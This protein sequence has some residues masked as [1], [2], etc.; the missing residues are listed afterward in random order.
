M[1]GGQQGIRPTSTTIERTNL[2]HIAIHLALTS[3]AHDTIK[4]LCANSHTNATFGEHFKILVVLY[5]ATQALQNSKDLY[6][7]P[8]AVVDNISRFDWTTIAIDA[9]LFKTLQGLNRQD[10]SKILND[11]K[12]ATIYDYIQ[13]YP[14]QA[15]NG[16]QAFTYAAEA[17]QLKSSEPVVATKASSP[18]PPPPPPPPK[19]E[20]LRDKKP[21]TGTASRVAEIKAEKGIN[22]KESH[23]RDAMLDQIRKGAISLRKVA[24]K[25]SEADEPIA[26]FWKTFAKQSEQALHYTEKDD[27]GRF[28]NRGEPFPYTLDMRKRTL[29]AVLETLKKFLETFKQQGIE[30]LAHNSQGQENLN[31]VPI[32]AT[33][34]QNLNEQTNYKSVLAGINKAKDDDVWNLSETP[35][36]ASIAAPPTTKTAEPEPTKK[37]EPEPVR[38]TEPENT[39]NRGAKTSKFGITLKPTRKREG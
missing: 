21:L 17:L 4:T 7:V 12:F 26:I 34:L 25:T 24:S 39:E 18:P 33:V 8:E 32:I 27:K 1:L 38:K 15:L 9:T 31:K 16:A 13:R 10:I 36:K 23:S 5:F 30:E 3:P 11:F 14:D 28:K 35:A 37:V 22:D 19:A 2:T 6:Q 29:D 20:A